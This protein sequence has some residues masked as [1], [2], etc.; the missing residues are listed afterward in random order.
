MTLQ[1]QYK[2]EGKLNIKG[3]FEGVVASILHQRGIEKN[4]KTD[5]ASQ[6]DPA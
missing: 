4:N 5:V 6:V 1:K 2:I 3:T